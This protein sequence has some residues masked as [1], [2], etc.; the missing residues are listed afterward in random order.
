[1]DAF[2]RL[3]PSLSGQRIKP[4]FAAQS[5][6]SCPVSVFSPLPPLSYFLLHSVW[7][8]PLFSPS[9][10]ATYSTL[11]PAE[12]IPISQSPFPPPVDVPDGILA[13]GIQ[14]VLPDFSHFADPIHP[15]PVS[16]AR[17]VSLLLALL[18]DP[19]GRVGL[20]VHFERCFRGDFPCL[21]DTCISS[22]VY[23]SLP[24]FRAGVPRCRPIRRVLYTSRP[25]DPSPNPSPS[26]CLFISTASP[27]L[28]HH[29]LCFSSLTG[30]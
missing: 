12:T 23:T 8:K 30:T 28:S 27:G 10:P 16:L 17:P 11:L 4:L 26:P 14:L 7:T 2:G 9:T 1:M 13:G 3:G 22:R 20:H 18:L 15:C 19:S 29:S 5:F 21:H 6:F 24:R 25:A